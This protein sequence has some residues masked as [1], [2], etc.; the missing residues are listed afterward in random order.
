MKYD[1]KCEWVKQTP[2]KEKIFIIQLYAIYKMDLILNDLKSN[3]KIR[4]KRVQKI[5]MERRVRWQYLYQIKQT[6]EQKNI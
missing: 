1:N 6:L 2:K 3:I 5:Q 4:A